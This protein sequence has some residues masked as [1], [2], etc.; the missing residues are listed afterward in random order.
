MGGP[1]TFEAVTS[2]ACAAAVSNSLGM[3]R[4]ISPSWLVYS[5]AGSARIR[6]TVLPRM[7]INVS[8]FVSLV[9]KLNRAMV[10]AF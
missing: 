7:S 2:L 6:L 1:G 5:I 10:T 8:T 3:N 9:G 4:L